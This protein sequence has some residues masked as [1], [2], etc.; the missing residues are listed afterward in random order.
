MITFM[1]VQTN[2]KLNFDYAYRMLEKSLD[3]KILTIVLK[4]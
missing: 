2:G 1:D 3:P 4:I